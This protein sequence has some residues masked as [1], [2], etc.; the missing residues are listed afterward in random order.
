MNRPLAATIV[1]LVATLFPLAARAESYVPVLGKAPW[2]CIH[3][4]LA[5]T[6]ESPLPGPTR[7][8]GK[9]TATAAPTILMTLGNYFLTAQI[10]GSSKLRLYD[11]A[12]LSR[13]SLKQFDLSA[14][15]PLAGGGT[16]DQNENTWWTGSL[17]TEPGKGGRVVRLT[18]DFS[19]A[20]YSEQP[21]SHLPAGAA[22]ITSFNTVSFVGGQILVGT[23]SPY[24]FFVSPQINAAGVFPWKETI[25]KR[26]FTLRGTPIISPSETYGPRPVQDGDGY[27]YINSSSS[28]LKLSYNARLGT[29]DREVVWAFRNPDSSNLA[30]SNPV[31]V[32][33]YVCVATMPASAAQYQQIYCLDRRTGALKR[34]FQPFPEPGIGAAHTLGT[35]EA[36][37]QL[38]T[39]AQSADGGG[40]VASYDLSTG[41]KSWPNV[42]LDNVSASFVVSA[43][44]RRLYIMATGRAGRGFELIAVD[45]DRGT[46]TVIDA[47]PSLGKPLPSLGALGPDGLYFPGLTNF[48][49]YED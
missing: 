16:L 27:V 17:P 6:K 30:V 21:A 45:T 2:P 31:V 41:K 1:A 33:A 3:Q 46:Q 48:S 26:Q 18:R 35:I 43:A 20:V 8:R 29:F 32:G 44:S 22:P 25:D 9:D 23:M 47:F 24:L 19:Q 40:G 10:A 15:F 37:Q 34:N 42:T 12:N 13:G 11:P 7:P 39:I 5:G 49:R 36:T 28:L 38:F 14:P 4:N